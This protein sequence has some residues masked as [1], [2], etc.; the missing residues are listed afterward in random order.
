[1]TAD[2]RLFVR[3]ASF[4]QNITKLDPYHTKFSYNGNAS[5]KQCNLTTLYSEYSESNKS[6]DTVTVSHNARG[7]H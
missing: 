1:M 7:A 3:V 5:E 4:H 2:G 6:K